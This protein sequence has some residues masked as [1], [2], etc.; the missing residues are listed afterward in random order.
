MYLGEWQVYSLPP[1]QAELAGVL[2]EVLEGADAETLIGFVHSFVSLG[3]EVERHPK[4]GLHARDSTSFDLVSFVGEKAVD[5][6]ALAVVSV[7]VGNR[8]RLEGY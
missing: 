3:R 2:V 5:D 7:E 6:L 8:E 4:R 1:Y